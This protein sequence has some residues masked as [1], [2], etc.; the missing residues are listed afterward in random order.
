MVLPLL[1]ATNNSISELE[2]EI[3]LVSSVVCHTAANLPKVTPRNKKIKDY[4]KD[5][6]L[7][8]LC[9]ASKASWRSWKQA[10]RPQGELLA[11]MKQAE[12]NIQKHIQIL[13]ARRQSERREER[14]RDKSNNRF[15]VPKMGTTHG[16]RL[17][18]SGHIITDKEAVK[19]AWAQHFTRL[20]SSKDSESPA[21]SNLNSLIY[22]YRLASFHNEDFVFDHDITTEETRKH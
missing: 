21:L 9:H 14:F 12:K 22:S 2:D 4:F 16:Q 20:S 8:D 18:V 6:H 10:G 7:K 15:R 1:G 5:N 11:N 3:L 13:R 17:L 19:D